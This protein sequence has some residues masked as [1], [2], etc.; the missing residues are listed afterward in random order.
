MN[1]YNHLIYMVLDE[2]K[3]FSDDFSYTEDHVLFLLT[4]YRGLIL[5]QQY[6]DIK[7]EIPESNFQTICLDL[8]EVPAYENDPCGG[9]Y[10]RSVQKI[11]SSMNI[12][13]PRVFTEDYYQ[14]EITYVSRERMRYVGN[15]KWLKNIVYCSIGPDEH[16]YFKTSNPQFYYLNKAK[17]TGVFEDPEKAS[18]LECNSEDTPCDIK[19]REFPLEEALIPQVIQLVVKELSGSVYRPKDNIN[20]ASDDLATMAQYLRSNMKSNFQKQI[21]GD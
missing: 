4:K 19:E 13:Q 20:S 7:K 5:K 9:S 10:M 18:E 15:N 21:D 8:E 11:P 3:G 6:K 16:L 14:G 2:L 17:L 1:T 12:T